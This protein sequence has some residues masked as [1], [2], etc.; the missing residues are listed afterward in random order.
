MKNKITLTIAA[1]LLGVAGHALGADDQPVTKLPYTPGLDLKAMDPSASPCEDFYQYA[2]GGWIKNNPIPPDKASWSVSDKLL[3]DNQRFLWGILETLAQQKTGRSANQQKISDYFTACMNQTAIDKLGVSPIQSVLAEI[4]ALKNKAELPALLAR[5]SLAAPGNFLFQIGVA[6]DHSDASQMIAELSASG[7]GLP[8]RFYYV[9]TDDRS[10][11]LRAK[12]LSHIAQMLTLGGDSSTLVDAQAATIMK[13]ETRLAYATLTIA[14]RGDPQQTFHRLDQQAVDALTPGFSWSAFWAATGIQRPAIYNVTEPTF[15]KEMGNLLRDLS[16]ADLKTY[17]RW[18]VIHGAAPLLSQP[19]VDE[20]FNFFGKTLD[21]T[22]QLAPR[23]QRCVSK[24]DMQFGDA[25]GQEFVHRTFGPKL[26]RDVLHMTS[27]IEI[28]MGQE[29]NQLDWMSPETKIRALKKLHGLTNKI[30]YPE[31]WRDYHAVLVTP[32]DFYGDTTRASRFELQRQLAKIGKPVDPSEWDITTPTVNAFYDPT[33]N[34]LNFPAGV[35][36]P[37]L[38]DPAMD[39]APNYGDTGDTLGHELTHGFDGQGRH[40]DEHGN[41]KEWW[42]KHDLNEFNKRAQ[43]VVNQYSNYIAIDDLKIN[44][45]LT[46]AED[47]ADLGGLV[48][49]WI[50]WKIEVH[51]KPQIN[52]DGLAPEQRFFVGYAQWACSSSRPDTARLNALTD[53]HS[54]DRYRVM[55]PMV[56]MP[57]FEKAFSCKRG[58]AMVPEQRCKIW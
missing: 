33:R 18:K 6:Q 13:I 47:I 19:L 52:I 25:L 42:N 43:C 26:K 24:V 41:L 27:Q 49:A 48:L 32:T 50:A 38:Y 46:K 14:E 12:Y 35:L 57:E 21:G 34:D 1:L 10:T 54:P 16:L 23:W 3:Q 58:Q 39:D 7:L 55:G 15:F 17:L 36:L 4:K 9:K 44:S 29:I 56:N 28:A 20:N 11:R 45:Q 40:Y 31:H 37:P 22:P 2:C 51:D 53:P 30:G 8:H 5:L